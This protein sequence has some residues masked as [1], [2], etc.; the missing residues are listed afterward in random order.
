MKNILLNIKNI[1]IGTLCIQEC[2]F[3]PWELE[4]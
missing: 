1:F 4:R 3:M 2:I